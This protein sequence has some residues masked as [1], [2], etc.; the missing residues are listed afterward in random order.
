MKR[1]SR[2][3]AQQCRYYEVSNIFEY[4]V[5][6]YLNGNITTFGELYQELC[7]EAR[8]DFIDFLLSEVEPIYWRVRFL[9]V[10]L[11]KQ[12]NTISYFFLAEACWQGS[13]HLSESHGNRITALRHRSSSNIFFKYSE[14]C[15]GR[16]VGKHCD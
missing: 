14:F 10:M 2:T 5:E 1:Y 15:G 9:K 6:T 8:K 13:T 12:N 3:V 4:M 11:F 16:S 7:K